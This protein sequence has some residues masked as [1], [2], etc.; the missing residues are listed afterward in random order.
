[1]A[2]LS[3]LLALLLAGALVYCAMVLYAARHYLRTRRQ[4]QS[5]GPPVSILKPLAG[6]EAALERN[7]RS[8]FDLDYN[9][10][11]LLCGVHT[12]Q[13][14]AAAV[15][16]RLRR[17]YPDVQAR[18]IV[19]GETSCPNAKVHNLGRMMAEARHDLLVMSDSDIRVTRDFLK[20]VA[21]EFAG[22]RLGLETCPYRAVPERGGSI[23][24]LLEAVG[25]NTEFISGVLAA[26][27]VEGMKFA[28]GPTIVARRAAIAAIGGMDR[29]KDHMAEDFSLGKLVAESGWEVELSSCAV[30]HHIGSHGLR[31]N[32]RHRLRWVRSTRRSRPA[33]YIGQIFTYPLPLALVLVCAVPSWWPA[34]IAASVMRALAAWAAAGWVLHDPL[35]A[36]HWYLVP[37]QDLAS[38]AFWLAGFFGKRFRWRHRTYEL[39]PDGRFKLLR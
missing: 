31:A 16:E 13:D 26:R 3:V 30:E 4:G 6:A 15:V 7:L 25:M 32:L 1:M 34:L 27:L 9:D 11:E 35:T 38:F 22:P 20:V 17:E 5:A 21:A 24:S 37:V 12:E 19:T 36:R 23:W 28:V 8:F 2:L 29:L 14:P 33:G 39:L 18:L 10:F